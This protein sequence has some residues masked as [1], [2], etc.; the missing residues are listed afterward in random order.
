[1]QRLV[2][3]GAAFLLAV[4]L[5]VL[6]PGGDMAAPAY[7]LTVGDEDFMVQMT[8]SGPDGALA[9]GGAC[10]GPIGP[11]N[12]C[13][14]WVVVTNLTPSPSAM[15]AYELTVQAVSVSPEAQLSSCFM[16]GLTHTS[17]PQ[18]LPQTGAVGPLSGPALLPGESVLWHLSARVSEE[19]RCQGSRAEVVVT[20]S[21]RDAGSGD[22]DDGDSA[23]GSDDSGGSGGAAGSDGPQAGEDGQPG[24]AQP[25]QSP[26]DGMVPSALPRT[27]S[28]GWTGGSNA[29]AWDMLA[30]LALAVGCAVLL[31][32]T[33]GRGRRS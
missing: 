31:L 32:G 17:Q 20:L 24:A 4:G 19:D 25:P 26:L 28:G 14:E 6:R 9:F 30:L 5:M 22:G 16:V 15:I 21:A 29:S 7:A 8:G 11:A 23:D 33:P 1:M 3:A 2:T 10:E 18:L 12:L 13:E 27:G